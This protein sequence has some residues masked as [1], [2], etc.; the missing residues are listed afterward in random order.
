MRWAWCAVV[1]LAACSATRTYDLDGGDLV[2]VG[3]A[4]VAIRGCARC[5]DDGS[6]GFTGQVKPLDGTDAYPANLTPDRVNG[7]GA[8]ADI[9]IVR[10][11]RYGIDNA[12]QPLCPAMP[13]FADVGDV[14]ARAIVGYLRSLPS[15]SR[16]VP[17]SMCPPVKPIPGPDMAAPTDL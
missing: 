9:E 13:R 8:W 6:T 17:S 3:A 2:P 12:G 11:I 5:H 1:G 4:Y 10:A 7:I 16:A 14:E 15:S